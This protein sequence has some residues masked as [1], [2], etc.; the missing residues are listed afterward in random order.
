LSLSPLAWQAYWQSG[1]ARFEDLEMNSC[2]AATGTIAGRRHVRLG[3]RLSLFLLA[4]VTGCNRSGLDLA[5]VEGIVTYN[6][7]PVADAG[8]MFAPAQGPSAMATTDA[9]GRFTLTTANHPGALIGE[10][11]VSISKVETIAIPQRRGFP[12]YQQKHQIPAKYADS[13][14]SELTAS[15]VD[16]DN[17]FEF[18]LN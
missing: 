16:D 9:E 4:L 12:L 17:H 5:P 2:S 15:V 6:G 13:A 14:T 1:S 7:S 3:G 10:H 18:N 11:R 8:V